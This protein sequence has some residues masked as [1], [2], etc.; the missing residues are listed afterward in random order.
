MGNRTFRPWLTP[1]GLATLVLPWGG[2]FALGVQAATLAPTVTTALRHTTASP[3]PLAQAAP[4]AL[5]QASTPEAEP[6]PAVTETDS[7]PPTDAEAEASNAEDFSP[8]PEE[9]EGTS[10]RPPATVAP[11]PE[12]AAPIPPDRVV[13]PLEY[14]NPDPNPLLIQ[15]QPPEVDIIGIQPLTLEDV[16]ELAYRNNPDLRVALLELERSQA[17]LREAQAALLP[18]VSLGGNFQGQN[19]RSAAFTLGGVTQ[20]EE[21]TGAV[22]GQVDVT[23]NIYSSGQREATIRAAEE[24]VRLSELEVERRRAVLRFNTINEY[25]D[26]Q[27]AIE[28]IR[29]STAFLDEAER[30]LRDTQLREE[31]GVGTRFDVLRAEVQAANARQQLAQAASDRS[32]AQRQLARRLNLPPSLDVTTVAVQ[33]AGSWPL[34]LEESIVQAYQS[35]VEL[36]QQLVQ[37][38]ISEQQQRAALAAVGPQVDLFAN[39]NLQNTFNNDD[40]FTDNYSFGIR[41]SWLLFDGGAANARADQRQADIEIADRRFEETRATVRFEVEQAYFTL[42]SNRQNIDTA[43]LAVEQAREALRLARLRF[44][45][46]VGTQLDVISAQSDLTEAEVNLIDAILG[47]NRSLAALER[48]V[49]NLPEPY[50]REL[51]F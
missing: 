31:V 10:D 47:Y 39:Y 37:R 13:D 33:I 41:A 9:S 45:A 36:E 42:E 8:L 43:R 15:T 18:Q 49:T 23:Y 48:A 29:I 4:E 2:W 6:D 44:E 20:T 11:S 34:S 40:G 7:P 50:Y 1:L 51:D 35:R 28:Q 21:L 16:L 30:N 27:R 38:Q 32:V 5:T 17:A 14:L 12:E 19:S 25:Y 46:G 3:G 24:Q 22:S 26:L